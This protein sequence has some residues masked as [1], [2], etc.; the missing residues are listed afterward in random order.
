MIRTRDEIRAERP[1]LSI[2]SGPEEAPGSTESAEQASGVDGPRG[3]DSRAIGTLSGG[4]AGCGR[5]VNE[6]RVCEGACEPL[7]GGE[8]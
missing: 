6:C 7:S 4:E 1:P 3:G 8:A 2:E 5:T